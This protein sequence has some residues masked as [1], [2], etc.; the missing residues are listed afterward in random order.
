[1]ANSP[2]SGALQRNAHYSVPVPVPGVSPEH[3]KPD[4]EPDPFAPDVQTEAHPGDVWQPQEISS[5]TAM[6]V[7]PVS[8]WGGRATP[9]PTSVPS[10]VA[11]EA[12]SVRMMAD[13]SVADYRPDVYVPYKHATQG[14]SIEFTSGRAP[15][16]AGEA[17]PEASQYLMMGTNAYDVTNKP[18]EVYS[19][20]ESNVGRYRLGMAIT[21][22]G[23]YEFHTKQGLDEELRAYNGMQPQFP[24]DKPRIED[25]APYTPNSSGTATWTLNPFQSPSMFALPTETASTD[26]MLADQQDPGS[27]FDD[28]GR[29]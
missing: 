20:G 13:H 10:Q 7:E 12:N 24:V 17:V 29:L 6:R 27:Q 3:T 18:N 19:E 22:F 5:H 2:Y 23:R 1:M 15:R 28:G 25:S 14:R 21:D 8:H 26:Y 4:P 11:L 16:V 9:V